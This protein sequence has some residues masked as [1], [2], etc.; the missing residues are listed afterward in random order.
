MPTVLY[1]ALYFIMVMITHGWEDFYGFNIGG[2]W[3]VSGILMFAATYAIG[4]ML[5]A[6]H[7]VSEKCV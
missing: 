7:K 3:Y 6:A 2:M 5:W 4:V 1:A